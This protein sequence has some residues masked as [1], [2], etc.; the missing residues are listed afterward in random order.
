MEK[1]IF[2]LYT[3]D[4]PKNSVKR[5][6]YVVREFLRYRK[7]TQN[8]ET[9]TLECEVLPGCAVTF[10]EYEEARNIILSYAYQNATKSDKAELFFCEGDCVQNDYGNDAFCKGE[11]SI[12]PKSLNLCP[13]YMDPSKF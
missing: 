8:K 4:L 5:A 12:H 10:E 6:C 13:H 3:K 9:K 1:E 2:A 7:V 11:F